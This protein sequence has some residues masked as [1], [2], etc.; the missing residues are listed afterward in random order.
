MCFSHMCV[1]VRVGGVWEWVSLGLISHLSWA[2]SFS[3]MFPSYFLSFLLLF[4]IC[5][6]LHDSHT[7]IHIRTYKCMQIKD[8]THKAFRALCQQTCNHQQLLLFTL[9]TN[10]T[11]RCS[12]CLNSSP[13][14]QT[15]GV[16]VSVCVFG[17]CVHM[18]V[19]V[20]SVWLHVCFKDLVAGGTTSFVCF[21]SHPSWF[22][23]PPSFSS[24]ISSPFYICSFLSALLPCYLFLEVCNS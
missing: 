1:C 18:C 2:D 6:S 7:H 20:G 23:S 22:P 19:Y 24:L 3:A 10:V 14:N 21:C 8:H 13:N 17:E 16:H 11:D 9:E 4:S 12:T 5:I 15:G